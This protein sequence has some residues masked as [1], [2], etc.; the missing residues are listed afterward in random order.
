[1]WM[2]V[3]T[4]IQIGCF[5]SRNYSVSE[6]V[7]FD[8]SIEAGSRRNSIKPGTTKPGPGTGPGHPV[9]RWWEAPKKLLSLAIFVPKMNF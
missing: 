5:N 6:R 3:E 9:D 2:I 4:L 8:A 7:F 1:M